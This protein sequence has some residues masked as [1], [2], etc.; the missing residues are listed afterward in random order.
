MK[1]KNLNIK[2]PKEKKN[3]IINHKEK[4]PKKK[5]KLKKF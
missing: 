3:Q 1:K 4:Y 2:N 5:K